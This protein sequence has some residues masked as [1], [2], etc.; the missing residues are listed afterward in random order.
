M[1]EGLWRGAGCLQ[2]G[3]LGWGGP[4]VPA[5][6]ADQALKGAQDPGLQDSS[7]ALGPCLLPP[8]LSLRR[9][10]FPSLLPPLSS[11]SPSHTWSGSWEIP[12]PA[13]SSAH[14]PQA[15]GALGALRSFVL[16]LHS[17]AWDTL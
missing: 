4:H 7:S 16:S 9:F 2:C 1:S 12:V 3:F 5:A 8:P 15:R 14:S 10:P 17:G 13:V 6:E 11:L